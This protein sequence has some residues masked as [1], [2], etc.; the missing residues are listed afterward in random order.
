MHGA[1]N[2][3]YNLNFIDWENEFERIYGA[4]SPSDD[5]QC[6]IPGM[7]RKIFEEIKAEDRAIDEQENFEGVELK[8]WQKLPC[9]IA[10]EDSKMM[11]CPICVEYYKKGDKVYVLPCN[12]T[13][14]T[15]CIEPWFEKNRS[16]PTCKLCLPK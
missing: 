6:P 2:G 1:K 11:T 4:E 14:H 7:S 5:E 3:K 13:F 12:H 9:K 10:S 8:F 15:K 16:C